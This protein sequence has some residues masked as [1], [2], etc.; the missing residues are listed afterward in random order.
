MKQR[1]I[2]ALCIIAAVLPPILL[3]GIWLNLLIGV[4]ALIEV[5][6]ILNCQFK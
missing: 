4:F 3:G 6:E 2:T 1:L 5:Y